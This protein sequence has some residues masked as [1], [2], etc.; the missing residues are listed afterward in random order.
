MTTPKPTIANL[1]LSATPV[2]RPLNEIRNKA[3]PSGAPPSCADQVL[4]RLC[5]ILP[6]PQTPSTTPRPQTHVSFTPAELTIQLP[7]AIQLF[8]SMKPNRYR[9]RRCQ[10]F[11]AII[12]A[13]PQESRPTETEATQ[14]YEYLFRSLETQDVRRYYEL[15]AQQL[16]RE[17]YP[18]RLTALGRKAAQRLPSESLNSSVQNASRAGPLPSIPSVPSPA[19]FAS[20]PVPSLRA[21]STAATA[22]DVLDIPALPKLN[23]H[24]VK[25]VLSKVQDQN[26]TR[27]AGPSPPQT[28]TKLKARNL[29]GQT[30]AGGVNK[31]MNRFIADEGRSH[32]T[33]V[34]FRK[35]P[36][37]LQGNFADIGRRPPPLTL[38]LSP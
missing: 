21:A 2:F 1:G 36:P 33:S 25:E 13:L 18:E 22:D 27:Q 14:M 7:P 11:N 17:A 10:E 30:V 31:E 37:R 3:G 26:R 28:P 38:S 23:E 5:H 8:G 20:S 12:S 29:K 19:P 16:H 35:E 9:F 4:A 34:K 32:A 15:Q 24:I 6:A